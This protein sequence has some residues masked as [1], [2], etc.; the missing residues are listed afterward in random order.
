M[1][2]IFF[3][4]IIDPLMHYLICTPGLNSCQPIISWLNLNIHELENYHPLAHV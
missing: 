4:L 2:K 3:S 1:K